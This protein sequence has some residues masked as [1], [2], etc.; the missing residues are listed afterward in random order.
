MAGRGDRLEDAIADVHLQV[1][2]LDFDQVRQ[3]VGVLLST[4]EVFE[5]VAVPAESYGLLSRLG[6]LAQD[7]LSKYES[8]RTSQ[9]VIVSRSLLRT[10]TWNPDFIQIGL[11]GEEVAAVLPP[12]EP[13]Y[14]D[15]PETG[16]REPVFASI[17]HWLLVEYLTDPRIMVV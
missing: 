14:I 13:V 5:C 10:V 16:K 8:I 17:Y 9:G 3:R 2:S 6:P 4:S 1:A 11:D 7:V 15:P 12:F